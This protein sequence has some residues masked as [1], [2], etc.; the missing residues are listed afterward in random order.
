MG[1]KRLVS[2]LIS[3]F[4]IMVSSAPFSIRRVTK[5]PV[6]HHLRSAVSEA[7]ESRLDSDRQP[8]ACTR[9]AQ[10]ISRLLGVI[11]WPRAFNRQRSN[12]IENGRSRRLF[13]RVEQMQQ[14]QWSGD[15]IDFQGKAARKIIYFLTKRLNSMAI[16]QR[17][18]IP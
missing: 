9:D 6:H 18:K 16:V 14:L 10:L 1:A 7:K 12:S 11:N 8:I 17:T 3:P 13:Q 5:Q 2:F 4:P 15:F